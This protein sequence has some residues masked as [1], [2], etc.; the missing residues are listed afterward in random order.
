[1][2]C[3]RPVGAAAVRQILNLIY[4]LR[5]AAVP[6]LVSRTDCPGQASAMNLSNEHEGKRVALIRAECLRRCAVMGRKW[7]DPPIRKQLHSC[8]AQLGGFSTEH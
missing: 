8:T 1:M 2:R 4:L 5:G 7:I 3:F 6:S